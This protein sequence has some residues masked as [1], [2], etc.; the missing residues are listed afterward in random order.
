[1]ACTPATTELAWMMSICSRRAIRAIA[2]TADTTLAIDLTI[3]SGSRIFGRVRLL[4]ENGTPIDLTWAFFNRKRKGL[5]LGSAAI[6]V[7][8]DGLSLVT[9]E[10]STC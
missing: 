7:Y 4:S 1:M 9:T 8:L 10:K 2:R 6:A 5:R 3:D